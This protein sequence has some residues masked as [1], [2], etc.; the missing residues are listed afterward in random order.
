MAVAL[1]IQG[2][3]SPAQDEALVAKGRY[4][5]A[6]GNCASC[7]TR[8]GGPPFGGGVAFPIAVDWSGEP[9]GT[10]YSSNISP[11]SETGIGDWTL[12]DFSR[13]MRAG[14]SRSGEHLYPV[15]PY[16]AFAGL[17]REDMAAIFA[18]IRSLEPVRSSPPQ[19]DL[20]FPLDWRGSLAVWKW[21]YADRGVHRPDGTRSAEWNRGAYLVRA[22]G[23]CG[24]CH[25]PRNLL[26]AEIPERA[27][28]GGIHFHPVSTDKE[29]L[30][31][32]VN[33]TP[34]ST[35]L[36]AWSTDDIANYL[37]TGHSPKAGRFGPMD[38]V[39]AEGTRHLT[40]N[41]A[42]AVAEYLKSL[43]PIEGDTESVPDPGQWEPA[44]A[45]YAEHCEDCHMASGRGNLFKAPPLAGS[46][47]VQAPSPYSLINIVLYGAAVP[48]DVA[49]PYR[50]WED[51]APY[52]D[53]LSDAEIAALGNYLGSAWGNRG[54]L[55]TEEDVARQ[56]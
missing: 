32:A 40:E 16:T 13:A 19:N 17:T 35:G 29:R 22:L 52:R 54:G 9:L 12:A 4:L 11:D 8:N 34:A 14:V 31:A 21:L 27:L 10:V 25:S 55:V 46:A 33:L 44:S 20:P 48:D 15:F 45:I 43:P 24:A 3:A 1:V 37:K 2:L 36:G 7:H 56:R 38:S 39:I 51:M 41:D 26:L 30:W 5:A 42:V 50:L 18:Y 47:V 49:A 6:L 28:S 23:H 53:M